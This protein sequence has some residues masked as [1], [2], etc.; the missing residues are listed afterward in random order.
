MRFFF[1]ALVA[2]GLSACQIVY[3]LPTRQ[4]NVIEQKQ[5]EQLK[6]GMTREQV[7]YLMGTPVASSAFRPDRWDY[8]SY[9]RSPRGESSQRVVS[10]YFKGDAL[11]RIEGQVAAS[12]AKASDTPDVQAVVEGEN[13]A[14][15]GKADTR[16]A[17]DRAAAGAAK[18]DIGQ[19]APP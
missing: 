3:K 19:P 1:L 18:P 5:L 8:V 4:G 9:Y 10:L 7:S 17:N 14:A 12:Q 13:K 16:E 6:P 2:L 15:K 11:E